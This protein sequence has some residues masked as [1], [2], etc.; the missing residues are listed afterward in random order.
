MLEK[1]FY[2]S[3]FICSMLALG[4]LLN[5]PIPSHD[6]ALLSTLSGKE[7]STSILIKNASVFDGNTMLGLRDIELKGGVITQISTELNAN[8][9]T[10]IDAHQRI[11]IPGLIDAHTHSYSDAL[12]L[13]LNFG[14]T[15]NI[16]MFSPRELTENMHEQRA[17]TQQNQQA[18]LFSAGMLATA[19][20]GHGTQFGIPVETINTPDEAEQWVSKRVKEGSDF[21]KLVYMPYSSFFKSIDRATAG[22]L[23]K[24]AHKQNLKAIAHVSS[25]AAAQEL[26]DDGIDGFVHIFAD[27]VASPEFAN[28]VKEQGVF[29]IPTLSVIS[30]A[31][32]QTH[33][34]TLSED[35]A[36]KSYLQ[37]GQAQQLT[38]NIGT[39][40]LPGFDLE[41]AL[42]NIQ[43]LH[44]AGV[45]ILAGSDAPNPGTSYGATL[46]QEIELLVEAGM[47][48]KQALSAATGAVAQHFNIEG[49]GMIKVGARADLVLLET[50]EIST[51]SSR[52]IAAIFK[53][54]Q[55]I[56]RKKASTSKTNSN[57]AL[58]SGVL[59]EFE[60]GLTAGSGHFNWVKTD[61]S[62]VN[63]QSTG[64][65]EHSGEALSVVAKI[66]A[67]FMFPWAGAS[68]FSNTAWDI[69]DYSNL[70]FKFKGGTANYRVMMFS[71]NQVG[72]PASKAFF[73]QSNQEWQ[74]LKFSISEFSGFDPSAFLGIAI[75]AG[76]AHGQFK[77]QLDDV[78]LTK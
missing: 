17:S 34:Q 70:E 58:A 36:I 48:P 1:T 72:P 11:L 4:V 42:Q 41:I 60:R 12:S 76:P 33:G 74:T 67:G 23:I 71:S 22:A 59:S 78:K 63:G 27:K 45:P 20:E 46:H 35:V 75:V 77:Y 8:E 51:L 39:A 28:Q 2:L 49:R 38:A 6:Q 32:H 5:L 62:M 43:L 69:N 53:N 30:S 14:V 29:V 37:A 65:L 19:D 25:L 9:H 66:N 40:K 44:N 64:S 50:R 13:S 56:T 47:S 18:D 61:D 7:G 68:V 54:G 10:V 16:D 24:H 3:L 57:P 15:S 26:L 52:K 55:L 73:F 31:A 21:I